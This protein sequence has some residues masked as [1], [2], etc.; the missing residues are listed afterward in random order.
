VHTLVTTSRGAIDPVDYRLRQTP[1]GWKIFDVIVKGVSY[2]R[3]YHDDTTRK[4]LRKAWMRRLHG[5]RGAIRAQ[6][7]AYHPPIHRAHARCPSISP[8]SMPQTSW[9]DAGFL[10]ANWEVRP[11]HGTLQRRD[12][13]PSEPVRVEPRVMAC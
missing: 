9:T 10:L 2:M 6:L 3:N 13:A 4:S 7:H 1:E 8:I 11:R 12:D 5:S